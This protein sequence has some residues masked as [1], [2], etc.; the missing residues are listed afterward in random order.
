MSAET[1][2]TASEIHFEFRMMDLIYNFLDYTEIF[3]FNKPV[4]ITPFPYMI[5]TLR[6]IYDVLRIVKST[7]GAIP[8]D[9]YYLYA[10]G[11][12][13]TDIIL[14]DS[15]ADQEDSDDTYSLK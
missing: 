4:Q 3:Y 9:M 15:I 1:K 2:Y 7:Y 14:E 12:R 6:I 10:I 5:R 11:N 8:E 13:H